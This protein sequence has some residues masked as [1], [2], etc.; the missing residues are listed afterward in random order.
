M[1]RLIGDK[2]SADFG[3]GVVVDNRPGANTLIGAQYVAKAEPDGYTLLMAIDST[4]VMNQYLYSKLPY[5]P[6]KDFAPNPRW[7]RRPSVCSW[8]TRRATRRRQKI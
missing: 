4:L 5:D 6:T 7:W 8:S 2:M 1:A 3:Q